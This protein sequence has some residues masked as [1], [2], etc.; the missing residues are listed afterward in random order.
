MTNVGQQLFYQRRDIDDLLYGR[1]YLIVHGRGR[2][3]DIFGEPHWFT[4]CNWVGYFQGVNYQ[5][6]ECSG[7]NDAGDGEPPPETPAH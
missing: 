7:Y 4:F 2:Y 5:S 6:S 1:A 3:V